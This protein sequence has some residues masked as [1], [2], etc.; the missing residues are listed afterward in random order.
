MA[1]KYTQGEWKVSK[2]R[3]SASAGSVKIR[4][5][6]GGTEV[7]LKANAVLIA[8]APEL[9]VKCRALV[10]ALLA[11]NSDFVTWD[12]VTDVMKILGK[13]GAL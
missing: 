4:Q 8:A 10:G 5:G 11:K 1:G 7:E 12:S 13:L 2:S 3:K 6:R 9:V